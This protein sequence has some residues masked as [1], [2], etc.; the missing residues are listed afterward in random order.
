MPQLCGVAEE[1]DHAPERMNDVGFRLAISTTITSI[2]GG[3]SSKVAERGID[4]EAASVWFDE[5]AQLAQREAFSYEA[6]ADLSVRLTALSFIMSD[7]ELV[8][9]EPDDL[10]ARVEV[11]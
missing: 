9:A 2:N 7:S 5:L 3:F 4:A 8:E 1:I 11:S 6:T 10:L